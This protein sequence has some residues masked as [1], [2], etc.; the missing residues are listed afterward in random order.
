MADGEQT[1]GHGGA[2]VGRPADERRSLTEW[3]T[4]HDAAAY[5]ERGLVSTGTTKHAGSA[6]VRGFTCGTAS[7][8]VAT[9]WRCVKVLAAAQCPA[10]RAAAAG[11]TVDLRYDAGL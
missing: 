3:C 7:G 2:H 1:M 9:A 11:A 5:E 4:L 6:V 10:Q 8:R